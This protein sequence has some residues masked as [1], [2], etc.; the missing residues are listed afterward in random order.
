MAIEFKFEE[1][2]FPAVTVCN[3]NPYKWTVIQDG[4]A[5][6]EDI[7]YLLDNYTAALGSQSDAC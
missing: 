4:G 3:L 7:K 1:R 5:P 2:Y 6:Y